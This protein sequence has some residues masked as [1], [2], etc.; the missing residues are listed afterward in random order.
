MHFVCPECHG[1]GMSSQFICCGECIEGSCCG[2]PDIEAATCRECDGEGTLSARRFLE[3]AIL[4]ND[5]S[6]VAKFETAVM[7]RESE[8]FFKQKD[9]A[10]SV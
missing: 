9:V 10:P 3:F 5:R 7:L 6:L 8:D 2:S 4:R 1:Q